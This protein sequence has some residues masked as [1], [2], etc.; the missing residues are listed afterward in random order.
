MWHLLNQSS[1]QECS[2]LLGC[3]QRSE[4][5]SLCFEDCLD[6]DQSLTW[7]AKPE[8]TSGQP[9][10]R[11]A[12]AYLLLEL[13]HQP[14]LLPLQGGHF[15]LGLFLGGR[16]L[17]KSYVG[18]LL[19]DGGQKG[20][21]PAKERKHPDFCLVLTAI[22]SNYCYYYLYFMGDETGLES[23]CCLPKFTLEE[24]VWAG[25]PFWS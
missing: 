3:S 11:L 12:Q 1:Y 22:L 24:M 2:A 15:L 23:I 16:K 25:I 19:T 7:D 17:Q 6:T 20:F 14:V 4:A 18:I 9:A 5:W 10:A 13:L 21:L 8:S